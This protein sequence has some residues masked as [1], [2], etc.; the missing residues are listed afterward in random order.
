MTAD[1]STPFIS[2]SP[3][4]YERNIIAGVIENLLLT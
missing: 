2:G 3:T 4:C 1:W